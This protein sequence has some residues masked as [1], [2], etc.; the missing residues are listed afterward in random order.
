MYNS[1]LYKLF[2]QIDEESES[3]FD[4]KSKPEQILQYFMQPYVPTQMNSLFL[5]YIEK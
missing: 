5:D 3:E 1:S 4:Y 2:W